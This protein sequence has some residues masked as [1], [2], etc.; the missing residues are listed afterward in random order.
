MC[1]CCEKSVYGQL[2]M[3]SS[4]VTRAQT[5]EPW[6][7]GLIKYHA[8]CIAEAQEQ[9]RSDL[10]ANFMLSIPILSWKIT[11]RLLG[12]GEWEIARLK[13]KKL[14]MDLLGFYSM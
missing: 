5:V 12:N 3:S 14:M 10:T 7:Q 4:Y 9:G 13:D 1:A 2:G 8:V 6:N 11:L